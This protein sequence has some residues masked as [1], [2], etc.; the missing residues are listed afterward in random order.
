MRASEPRAIRNKW[1]LDQIKEH[2]NE[3]VWHARGLSTE[4]LTLLK[5]LGYRLEPCLGSHA[6]EGKWRVYW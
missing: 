2:A 1:L 5:A 3:G 6:S 4:D